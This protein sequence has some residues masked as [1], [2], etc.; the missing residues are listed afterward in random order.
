MSN[1]AEITPDTKDWTWVLDTTC[2]ECGYDAGAVADLAEVA[3]ELRRTADDWALVL[4]APG[5]TTRPRP[6]VWSPAEYGAHVR[7]VHRVF[8]TRLELMLGADAPGFANWDQDATALEE[9]YDRADPVE[10]ADELLA[11][12]SAV[13]DRYDAVPDDALERTGARSDGSTFTVASLAR[14]HLHDIVHHLW[15]VR[16]G[17]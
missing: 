17:A 2:P 10:V 5:A 3:R 4:R 9:R 7:D 11:A 12:A 15:D 16:L 6:D 1:P 13:A 14:Y 8:A